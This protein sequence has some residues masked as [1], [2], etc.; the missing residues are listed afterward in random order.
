LLFSA[1]DQTVK[2]RARGDNDRLGTDGAAVA[3]ADANGSLV[4]AVVGR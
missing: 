3:E 1:V 4:L 2:K